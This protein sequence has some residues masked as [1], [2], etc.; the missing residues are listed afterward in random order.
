MTERLRRQ[1]R[2]FTLVELL[3][4]IGIIGLLAGIIAAMLGSARDRARTNRAEED[5]RNLIVATDLLVHD[6]D[7]L[8]N[9]FAASRCI[10]AVEGNEVLLNAEDGG[11]TGTGTDYPDWDGPYLRVEPVDPWSNPYWFDHDYDCDNG[12]PMG[13]PSF[14]GVV[15][16]VVSS[17]PNG[18][19]LDIEDSDNIIRMRCR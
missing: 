12:M 18:S 6:T 17:G 2:G 14:G 5:L 10:Y 11:L 7:L 3:V 15:Q 1:T 16:A 13:C 4:V 8:P 9:R 19:A